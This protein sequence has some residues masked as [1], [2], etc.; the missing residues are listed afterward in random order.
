MQNNIARLGFCLAA[1]AALAVPAAAQAVETVVVTAGPPDPVGD[2]AFSVVRL[3]AAELDA[4]PQ[5]DVALAQV[6]GLS[7][8]RRNSSLSANPSTQGVSLRSIA[9]SGAGRALVTLDGV[10]QNDP[11][12]GWVI[13]SSLPPEAL[14]GAEIVRG[15]GAG[16][17]GAGALTGVIAFQEK[18]DVGLA[19]DVSGGGFRRAAAAGGAEWGKVLL[20]GV[21]SA[22]AS[23]GWIPVS[24]AQRGPADDAVTL[25]ARNASVRAQ[26][27]PSAGTLIAARVGAYEEMRQSGLV[28]TSS[29]ADGI[30][31]SLTVAHPESGDALGWRLQ[32]WLHESGFSQVS[33]TIAPGRAYT[34]PS[35]D[36]Y[37]TPAVGW[38]ANGALRGS[39]PAFDWEIGADARAARGNS[40]EHYSYVSGA[41][42]QN[43]VSGGDNLVGGLY[44]EVAHRSGSW[45]FTLGGRADAWSSTDGH[46]VESSLSSGAMTRDR[47]WP[48]RSGILPTA[49][50]GI[51]HD[52]SDGLYLRTAAYEGFRAPSL[53]E[54]YRPFRLGNNITEANAALTP[55]TLYGVEISA[56]G[57]RGAFTWDLTAFWNQ[58]HRAITNVTIGRGPG[59]FPDAG[60]VSTG[61]LLIQKQNAGDVNA[62]GIE[63]S[64]RYGF[65]GIALQAAFDVLDQRVHGGAG[66]SQLTGLRP[67]QAPRATITG[68]FATPLTEGWSLSADVHYE[69]ARYADDQNT[70][71]LA[72]AFTLDAKLS[73][74]VTDR[75]VLY[76]AGDNV[77]NARVVTTESADGVTNYGAPRIL[78]AGLSFT[79]AP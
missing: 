51:R 55:E 33:A 57:V 77:L 63:G 1:V 40:D 31:A 75:L 66:A 59:V 9:P 36:Q 20:F 12:G 26:F 6:P 25:D 49:R 67:V 41:F 16:P 79:T 43:R 69:S 74:A 39:S 76:V 46:L 53:N 58:L 52:F 45:L 4:S 7:L 34:T 32:A 10:P 37:A 42:T 44:A 2:G 18:T 23:D 72:P 22:E 30:V 68:G 62:P 70:L 50:G 21:A 73:C 19:A 60:F 35:D 71:R 64:L 56:G 5:L 61:G 54:L 29:K 17:Y 47:R 78:R 27:S 3:D 48:S 28:G 24:P 65:D 15:A 8:F 14:A 13:W 11:F 38:G